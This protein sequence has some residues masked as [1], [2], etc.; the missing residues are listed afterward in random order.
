MKV[1]YVEGTWFAVPLRNGGFAVGLV[2]RATS[3]GP[4]V[5]AYLFG[6]TY[7]T[8]PTLSEVSP[9]DPSSAIKVA[10]IGDLHLIDGTWPILGL[11]SDFRRS[12][13]PFPRFVRTDEIAGRAWA[14]EYSEDDPG[15]AISE[16]AIDVG[17]SSL[18]RDAAL[19]AGA[20][21]LVLTK[22]L[23]RS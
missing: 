17:T 18:D 8:I 22:I 7:R 9:R 1:N 23:G 15:R 12:M 5:L 19:G 13:W 2:A 6:P 14:V 3:K 20:V 10:R 11:A 16:I 21:E 4:C